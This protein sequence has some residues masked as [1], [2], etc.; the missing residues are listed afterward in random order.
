MRFSVSKTRLSVAVAAVLLAGVAVTARAQFF[1]LL[2]G[3]PSACTSK[4]VAFASPAVFA[5]P[6][7]FAGC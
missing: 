5:G 1:G 7:V 6:V 2:G 4:G 3:P